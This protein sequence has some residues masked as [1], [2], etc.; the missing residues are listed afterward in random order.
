MK[1]RFELWIDE[2]VKKEA[3]RIVDKSGGKYR[4]LAHYFE[5]AVREKNEREGDVETPA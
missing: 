2:K 5:Q 4:S 1:I 3:Q